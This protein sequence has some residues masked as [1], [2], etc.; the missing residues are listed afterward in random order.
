MYSAHAAKQT[1]ELP[2]IATPET[3]LSKFN[4]AD[5]LAM[6]CHEIST[7]LAAIVGLSRILSNI[8]YSARNRIECS[9]MLRD[10]S[11][12]LT[13]LMR[14]MLDCSKLN[15]GM[16]ELE[17]I[18][19]DLAQIVREAGNII[20]LKIAEKGLN[21]HV[22]FAP[23][24]PLHYLGDPLRIQQILLNLLSNAVKFTEKGDI[25]LHVHASIDENGIEQLCITVKDTGIGIA[26]EQ[27]HAIFG[28]YVQANTSISRTYGGT[29]LGLCISYE[30]ARLMQGTIKVKSRAGKGSDF[31]LM[32]PL[33]KISS[34]GARI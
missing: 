32:L 20:A 26:K 7:P 22:H 3:T 5:Y 30:L 29:G 2:S 33:Q 27:L 11:N 14:N 12:M 23:D 6:M 13:G 24:L 9:E 34:L 19:F 16:M 1:T 8:E 17:M 4:D 18:R 10:S 21:S 28:K 15:A 31:T 25:T